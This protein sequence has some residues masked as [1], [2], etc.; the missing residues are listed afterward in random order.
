M[1]EN[2]NEIENKM[3][4]VLWDDIG[5][6]CLGDF[7]TPQEADCHIP[8]KYDIDTKVTETYEV[9]IRDDNKN[10]FEHRVEVYNKSTGE[11]ERYLIECCKIVNGEV[12]PVTFEEEFYGK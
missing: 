12:I 8:Y 4:Y 3:F 5:G 10:Y 2:C 1:C 11:I 9:V 6:G 7:K